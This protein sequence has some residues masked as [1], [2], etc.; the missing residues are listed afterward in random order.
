[1]SR[2]SIIVPVY[3]NSETLELLYKD[4]KE[5][6]FSNTKDYELIMVDDGSTDDSWIKMKNIAEMDENVKIIKLSRNFGSHAAMFAGIMKCTGDCVAIKSADLQENS[7]VILQMQRSWEK[8]N[9]VVLAVRADREE[10]IFQKSFAKIY[11]FLMRKFAISTMPKEGFD[12]F[13]IDR[14]VIEVLKLLDEK[15]SALTL[16]I[17]WAGFKTES[18]YYVRKKREFGKS[19][20]TFSKKIKLVIDSLMGF[21]FFPIRFIS[22]VGVAFFIF[23]LFYTMFLI[24][25]RAFFGAEVQGWTTLM[26]LILFTSGIIMLML[27]TLGEYLWRSFDAT[28]NRPIFIIDETEGFE[29]ER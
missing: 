26:V 22:G 16:Q 7:E 18:I 21:S 10:G 19:K 13:L 4:L 28:R 29:R 27:G 6:V 25:N 11:Y 12:C 2:L 8:G 1:M 23:S 3:E 24:I 5:N 20:W 17:L 14:K 15:N 9:S